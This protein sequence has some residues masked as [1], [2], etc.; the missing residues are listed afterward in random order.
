M[1][2]GEA[3]PRKTKAAAEPQ[4]SPIEAEWNKL[5][6]D[7]KDAALKTYGAKSKFVLGDKLKH[8]SFGDGIVGKLIHPNKIEVIFQQ[9]VKVLIHGGA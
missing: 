5:M 3:K 1:A 6:N 4:A 7:H 2:K 8:P 9:E